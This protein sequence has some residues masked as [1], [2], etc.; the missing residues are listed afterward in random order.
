[1][2]FVLLNILIQ[3]ERTRIQLIDICKITVIRI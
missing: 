1:M 3:I 2:R